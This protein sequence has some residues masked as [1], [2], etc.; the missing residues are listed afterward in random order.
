METEIKVCQNCKQDFKIFSEDL[1]FYEQMTVPLPTFCPD[2]RAQRRFMWR[3]ERTLYKRKCDLCQKSFICLYT[4]DAPYTIYCKECWY[5]DGWDPISF[6][7]D[8]NPSKTFFEQF[9]DLMHKVPRL[10]IWTVQCAN[11]EYTNQ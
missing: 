7:V 10:G 8:Y 5:G 1:T 2:C 4:E 6:G 3:N 9:K 11:S